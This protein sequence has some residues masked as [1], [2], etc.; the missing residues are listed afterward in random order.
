MASPLFSRGEL[1]TKVVFYMDQP[2]L[3]GWYFSR[4]T[5]EKPFSVSLVNQ[6]F[7]PISKQVETVENAFV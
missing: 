6:L 5:G 3:I 1:G 7:Q 2:L 4:S